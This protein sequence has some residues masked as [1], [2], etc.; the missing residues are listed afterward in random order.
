MSTFTMNLSQIQDEVF[1][2]ARQGMSVGEISARLRRSAKQTGHERIPATWVRAWLRDAGLYHAV[3]R[4][5][6]GRG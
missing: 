1:L 3:S 4:G 5:G 6:K 2:L